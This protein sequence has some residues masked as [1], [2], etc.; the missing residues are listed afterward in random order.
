VLGHLAGLAVRKGEEDDIVAV[1]H[2]GLGGLELEVRERAQV[3]LDGDERRP[4]VRVRRDSADFELRMGGE[5]P[6]QLAP[7]VAAG[8]GNGDGK[9][10][11]GLLVSCSARSVDGGRCVR[12]RLS[13]TGPAACESSPIVAVRRDGAARDA[14]HG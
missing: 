7:G 8:A 13:R 1:E 6:E 11:E 2:L 14:A 12:R 5:Q 10:H 3:G 4:G 9:G